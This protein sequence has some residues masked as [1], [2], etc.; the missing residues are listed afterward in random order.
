MVCGCFYVCVHFHWLKRLW[1]LQW[2]NGRGSLSSFQAY[3]EFSSLRISAMTKIAFI[4]W[5]RKGSEDER[6]GGR[7]RKVPM[8]AGLK[9]QKQKR[10]SRFKE[11]MRSVLHKGKLRGFWTEKR[12]QLV[13]QCGF[14]IHG[15]GELTLPGHFK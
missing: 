1:L 11:W 9:I 8:V 12:T 14:L 10:K 3:H 4:S 13:L 15:Y 7:E 2:W 5:K 6:K